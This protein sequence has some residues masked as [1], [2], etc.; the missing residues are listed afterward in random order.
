[1]VRSDFAR[2]YC[3]S[4]LLVCRSTLTRVSHATA[5]PTRRLRGVAC[6]RRPP[7]PPL[8][9]RWP[10]RS[11]RSCPVRCH[12][13]AETTGWTSS[14]A[15]GAVRAARTTVDRPAGPRW[16]A[17]CRTRWRSLWGT[18][19]LTGL[20]VRG[21][22]A[23]V[24]SHGYDPQSYRSVTVVHDKYAECILWPITLMQAKIS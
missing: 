19:S 11:C 13:T 6:Q 10:P 20:L 8:H 14:W 7:S 18:H 22:H 5:L 1:M 23:W 15:T 3:S 4:R 9:L 24:A 12:W 2:T 17:T 16:P 21:S